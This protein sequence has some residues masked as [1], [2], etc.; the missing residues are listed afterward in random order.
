MSAHTFLFNTNKLLRNSFFLYI[1][2]IPLYLTNS[3]TTLMVIII[4]FACYG[5]NA[6]YYIGTDI[7]GSIRMPAF[8]CGIFGHKPTTHAVNTRGNI[9]EVLF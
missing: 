8:F 2:F 5:H 9:I 7:G 6:Y 4:W 3:F 1:F